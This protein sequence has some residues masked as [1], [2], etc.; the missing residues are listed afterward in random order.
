MLCTYRYVLP[1]LQAKNPVRNGQGWLWHTQVS[2]SDKTTCVPLYI[3][4]SVEGEVSPLH[5]RVAR[6]ELVT[7]LTHTR[8]QVDNG[9]TC[10]Q[11]S[12]Q[13]PNDTSVCGHVMHRDGVVSIVRGVY[14]IRRHPVTEAPPSAPCIVVRAYVFHSCIPSERSRKA[15]Y[16]RFGIVRIHPESR[17]LSSE[18]PKQRLGEHHHHPAECAGMWKLI[19][20]CLAKVVRSPKRFGMSLYSRYA[21]VYSMLCIVLKLLND[22]SV[23]V[24]QVAY[25]MLQFRITTHH[26][27]VQCCP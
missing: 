8:G 26:A 3:A 24:F 19:S 7:I 20:C 22:E 14:N 11:M 21:P 10:L 12:H 18:H 9:I 25:V 6:N 17:S 27:M 13:T 16:D 4:S 2:E 5:R 15:R 1:R 23:L